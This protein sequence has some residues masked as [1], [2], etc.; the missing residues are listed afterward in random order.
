[1]A[2]RLDPTEQNCSWVEV[3]NGEYRNPPD[4]TADALEYIA[5]VHEETTGAFPSV[6]H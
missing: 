2:E 6:D 4:K 5:T 1:M 3:L